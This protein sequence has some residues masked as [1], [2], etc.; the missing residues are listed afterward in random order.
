MGRADQHRGTFTSCLRDV[1]SLRMKRR[2]V[3]PG[4]GVRDEGPKVR[5]GCGGAGPGGLC[6]VRR[7]GVHRFAIGAT[8]CRPCRRRVE[9]WLRC[10]RR[11]DRQS[12]E[13]RPRGPSPRRRPAARWLIRRRRL[14]AELERQPTS[15]VHR[16]LHGERPTRPGIPETRRAWA[17]D[18]ASGSQHP[19]SLTGWAWPS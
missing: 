5:A 14:S 11:H 18:L 10:R 16:P 6:A 8:T 13:R 1:R 17:R 19:R 15:I 7:C 3:E 4:I 2:C 9:G 12:L